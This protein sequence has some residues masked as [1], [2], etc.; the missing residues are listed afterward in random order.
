MLQKKIIMH[1]RNKARIL[2]STTIITIIFVLIYFFIVRQ[3]YNSNVN[4]DIINLYTGL[5]YE[6]YFV[7]KISKNTSIAAGNNTYEFV[8]K[9]E[10]S[11]NSFEQHILK[12]NFV[13]TAD[14]NDSRYPVD[15]FKIYINHESTSTIYIVFDKS[16]KNVIL[17]AIK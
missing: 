15:R 6:D 14:L 1:N 4:H 2:I 9:K 5:D 10:V 7:T 16:S 3:S 17:Q 13:E 11:I 12:K 8:L